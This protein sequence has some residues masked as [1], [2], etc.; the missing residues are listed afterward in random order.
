MAALLLAAGA[1]RRFGGD[2]KLLADLGGRPLV[3][4][5]AE[6]LAMIDVQFRIAAIVDDTV[7]DLL[8]RLGFRTIVVP[9]G[10]EQSQSLALGVRE[11][12]RLGVDHVLLVLGDMPFVPTTA[13]VNLM[14]LA[15]HG[16]VCMRRGAQRMPPAIFPAHRF[17]EL[18]ALRGDRGA[19]AMLSAVPDEQTLPLTAEQA[20]D[21]DDA[22]T[23]LRAASLVPRG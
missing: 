3:S 18:V 2:N 7:A 16:V 6:N 20:I 8:A 17:P 10:S 13:L 12:E 4:H 1:S 22:T 11:A 23:L 9:A 15:G 21:V 19:R 14:A 5:T